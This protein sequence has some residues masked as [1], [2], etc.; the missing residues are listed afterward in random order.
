M[1]FSHNGK[2]FLNDALTEENRRWRR[3]TLSVNIKITFLSWIMEFIMGSAA[4]A[5]WHLG[6][7]SLPVPHLLTLF[8]I[9]MAFIVVPFTYVLD[10]E[11]TKQII[12][13]ENWFI[14]IKSAFMPQ[15]QVAPILDR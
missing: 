12:V 9:T 3:N 1:N 8:I 11:V 14:G 15:P 7:K 4:I 10:R 5:I 13:L 6:N 2:N